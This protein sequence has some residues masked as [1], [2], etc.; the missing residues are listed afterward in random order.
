VKN[1]FSSGNAD[2]TGEKTAFQAETHL[3]RSGV[4]FFLSA[5]K[6]G[7]HSGKADLRRMAS[8]AANAAVRGTTLAYLRHDTPALRAMLQLAAL[9]C[10]ER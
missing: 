10:R 5:P 1:C 4:L 8:R 7:F 6:A 3:F 9:T 2:A